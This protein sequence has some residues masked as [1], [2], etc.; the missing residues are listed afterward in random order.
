MVIKKN[1]PAEGGGG[2]WMDEFGGAE[3]TGHLVVVVALGS[4]PGAS[5]LQNSST[6]VF[7]TPMLSLSMDSLSGLTVARWHSA[8]AFQA[9]ERWD[10]VTVG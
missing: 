7:Q 1:L 2:K 6:Q 9:L 8:W 10:G 4:S 5:C 3:E